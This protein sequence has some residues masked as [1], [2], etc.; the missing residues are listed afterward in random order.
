M[1]QSKGLQVLD[2]LCLS[3]QMLDH[4]YDGLHVYVAGLKHDYLRLAPVYLRCW[5]IVDVV[6]RIR[7]IAQCTPGLNVKCLEVRRFLGE[8]TAAEHFR[9]YILHLHSEM[10]N[11]PET[12]HPVW[13]SLSWVD[14]EEPTVSH[15]AFSASQVEKTTYT[16]C[17]WDTEEKK[18]V[19]T[20]S[21]GMRDCLFHFDPIVGACTQ[22]RDF[23]LPWVHTR[24]ASNV[25]ADTR[26]PIASIRVVDSGTSNVVST[27]PSA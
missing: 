18:W 23:V 25:P 21:L 16:S 2:S 17:I 8:T 5:S 20:V 10:A 1:L 4:L 19:S 6:H 7:E 13:G 15:I 24:Y 9:H 11:R 26:L 27:S 22:F 12:L 14:V 3:Y